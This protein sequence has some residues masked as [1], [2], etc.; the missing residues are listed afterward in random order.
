MGA[1]KAREAEEVEEVKEVEEDGSREI[2][3]ER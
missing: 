3:R 2:H 1:E